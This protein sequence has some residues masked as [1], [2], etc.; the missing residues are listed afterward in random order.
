M[1]G[2]TLITARY[3]DNERA[4]VEAL[5]RDDNNPEIMREETI[6]NDQDEFKE[7][8]THITE[9]ELHE[10]AVN[11]WRDQRKNFINTVKQISQE[12][13]TWIEPDIPDWSEINP[14]QKFFDKML[15]VCSIPE[16][17]IKNEELFKFKLA[18]F[19]IPHI[20]E[21]TDRKL[22]AELRKAKTYAQIFGAIAQF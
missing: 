19:E 6:G 9:Y 3:T 4:I 21:S 8:L 1:K 7:L 15:E 20:K 2:H 22:K 13:G 18:A 11:Y 12:E 10:N 5:W 14:D 17:K 16:D